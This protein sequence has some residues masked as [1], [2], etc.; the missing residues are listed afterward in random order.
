MSFATLADG[1]RVRYEARGPVDASPVL[2]LCG[3]TVPLETFDRNFGALADQGLRV[4]RF[5]YP[6][7]GL[8]DR[9][10]AAYDLEFFA[11]AAVAFLDALGEH[12]PVSLV[13][14]SMGGAVAARMAAGWPGRVARLALVDPLFFTLRSPWH[15]KLLWLP[16]VGEVTF[17]LAG[18]VLLAT[19]QASDFADQSAY[20]DFLPHYRRSFQRRGFSRAVL[21]TLRSTPRWTVTPAFVGLGQS[22][23]VL[24]IWGTQDRTIPYDL[25]AELRTLMG[26]CEFLAV[27]GAGHVPQWERPESVNPALARFLGAAV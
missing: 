6:G 7:R 17:G 23:R 5:D 4:Y 11:R 10:R 8:S 12:R 13:G 27:E 2:F 1:T 19:G 20:R 3:I 22:H 21:T 18:R 16:L 14:L 26:P 24:L 25:A 9:P 15:H